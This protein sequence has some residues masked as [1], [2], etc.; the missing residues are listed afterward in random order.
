MVFFYAQ[1]T[2]KQLRSSNYTCDRLTPYQE[3]ITLGSTSQPS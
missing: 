1:I 2:R 3:L